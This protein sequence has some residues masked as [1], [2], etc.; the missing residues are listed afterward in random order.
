MRPNEQYNILLMNK[1]FCDLNPLEAGWHKWEI[2]S[3]LKVGPTEREYYVLHYVISGK[4]V[5]VS[6]GVEHKVS[7]GDYFLIKPNR[8]VSY[9]ADNEKPWFYVWIGFDGR[10]SEYFNDI[11]DTGAVCESQYFLD[12]FHAEDSGGRYEEFLVGKLFMIYHSFLSVKKDAP[13][14]AM[15]VKNF[16]KRN[17]MN[18]VSV[19]ALAESLGVNRI[20]LTR[21][22]KADY[23]ISIKKYL[24]SVRMSHAKRFIEDGHSV[25]E[26]ADMVGYSDV[27]AFSKMF[28]SYFGISPSSIKDKNGGSSV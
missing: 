17:Y 15:R 8:L 10:L 26:A 18:D 9:Y 27:F 11:P 7:A 22:F 25:S 20:Y 19:E 23:G 14:Y 4:G 16:I 3:G 2:N 28:K 1:H 5:F 24:V 12:V 21:L 6:D 13:C